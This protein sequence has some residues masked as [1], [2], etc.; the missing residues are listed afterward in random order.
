ML[1]SI[2]DEH[3]VCGG[4]PESENPVQVQTRA[5]RDAPSAS[6]RSSKRFR[7]GWGLEGEIFS[8]RWR[9]ELLIWTENWMCAQRPSRA[10]AERQWSRPGLGL[11]TGERGWTR[12]DQYVFP[13]FIHSAFPLALPFCSLPILIHF[14]VISLVCLNSSRLFTQ[15]A[16]GTVTTLILTVWELF[17][18]GVGW[19]HV[20]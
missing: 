8:P 19:T 6:R 3:C 7:G 12:H 18:G 5:N 16:L 15:F 4:G 20:H 11:T 10:W 1:P 13:S 17:T 14:S 9:S 2:A